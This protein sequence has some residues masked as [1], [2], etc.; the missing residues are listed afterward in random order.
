MNIA[1]TLTLLVANVVANATDTES[2]LM[3]FIR[4]FDLA[5]KSST[6]LV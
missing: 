1:R 4:T 5:R 3:M 2:L 6:T